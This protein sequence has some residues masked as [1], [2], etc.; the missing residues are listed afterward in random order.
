MRRCRTPPTALWRGSSSTPGRDR[1][2]RHRPVAVL[3]D[4]RL[5]ADSRRGRDD[6]EGGRLVRQRVGLL[7]PPG[8]PGAEGAV[9]PGPRARPDGSRSAG[10][11]VTE[12]SEIGGP[13]EE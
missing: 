13:D 3:L 6:V 11:I 8:G 1:L 2:D 10:D 4:R 5:P 9:S 7:E 12:R